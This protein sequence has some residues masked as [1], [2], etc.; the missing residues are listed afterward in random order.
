MDDEYD[1]AELEALASVLGT[2][3]G[4]HGAFGIAL[5]LLIVGELRGLFGDD[6]AEAAAAAKRTR[7]RNANL[8]RDRGFA[9]TAMDQL[10]DTHFKRM[11][12]LSRQAFDALLE[13]VSDLL[14]GEEEYGV[15]SSGSPITPKTK[16]AVALRW[17]AGGS[18]IDICFEFGIGFGG[19]FQDGGVLWGTLEAL[20]A[21]MD[22]GFPF[23]D[24]AELRKVADGFARYSNGHMRDCTLAIDGWVCRTRKPNAREVQN[25][26]A[27]RNR[28]DCWGIVV[29]AGCD[30]NLRFLMFS[31]ISTGSTNDVLAWDFCAMKKLLEEG[32]LP[33][34]FYWIGDEAFVNTSQLLLP[35]SG[36]GLQV[37][38][39][40]FNFHLSSMRQCIE[41]AFSLLVERWGI[42][43]RP[44]RCAYRRWTLVCTVAAKLHNYAI[45][46]NEGTGNDI[47][48]RLD[49]DWE[50]G[51]APVV[52]MNG[53]DGEGEGDMEGVRVRPTGDTRRE[54]TEYLQAQG[55]RRPLH[56][57]ANSRA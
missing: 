36:R 44:L 31:A 5:S 25:P 24:T 37:W 54:I 34:P 51:D 1:P 12:R 49:D 43:W 23:H 35:W 33:R 20:D 46:M 26:M 18:F 57:A 17:L 15:Y 41:R 3:L 22:L 56:A 53:N 42:F 32:A 29:L 27:Y 45:D 40:S 7:H 28:H 9:L 39:D 4:L 48:R 14:V 19:F 50:D 11:F 38:K 30:S 21:A 8:Q 55:V 2:L 16:L 47:L 52:Q 10:S 6:L 13:K